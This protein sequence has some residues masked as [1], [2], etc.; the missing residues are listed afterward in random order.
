MSF[1]PNLFLSNIKAK[2]G[3]A[4]PSRFQIILPIPQYLGNYISSTF[5]ESIVNLPNSIFSDL[6]TKVLGAEDSGKKYSKSDITRYLGLQC[7]ST[8][9]PGKQIQTQEARIYGP[10]YKVPYR[11]DYQDINFTFLCTNEFYERKLFDRWLEVI[12][13]TDTN[14]VRFP[15]GVDNRPGQGYMTDVKIVQYDDFIK[16]IY[17]VQLIDAFPIAISSQPLSWAEEN[18]HRLTVQFTYQRFQTIYDGGYD[19]VAAATEILGSS[20]GGISINK[21]L[22]P[23]ARGLTQTLNR[24]F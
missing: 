1:L 2:D 14:N 15:R 5:L 17:A 3:L 19:I 24:I 4:R 22:D 18:F 10:T 6:T 12:I 23:Q 21:L 20:I 16:Q 8:E 11:A 7:E 13:P 9:L